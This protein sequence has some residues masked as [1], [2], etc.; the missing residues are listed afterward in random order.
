[1]ARQQPVPLTPLADAIRQLLPALLPVTDSETIAPLAAVGRILSNDFKAPLSVPPWDNSAMDGYAVRTADLE[2]MPQQLRLTQR[3]VAGSR[4]QPLRPGE[5]ARIFTGAPL[6]VG[7]DAVVMQ[8]NARTVAGEVLI[9]QRVAA[10]ENVRRA[11]GDMQAGRILFQAGHRLRPQDLGVLGAVGCTALQVRRKPRVALFSTG[12]ELVPPGSALAEGP[13]G[14]QPAPTAAIYNAN[15]YSLTALLA[16][17]PAEVIDFG[18]VADQVDASLRV[19]RQAAASADCIIST[20]GVSVGEED[21]VRAA[22]TAGGSLELWQLAIKPGKP[23]A[24]G[25]VDGTRFFGLPGNPVSAFVTFVLLVRPLLLSMLG[26]QRAF[27]RPMPLPAGFDTLR[28]GPRQEYL[29]VRLHRDHRSG[30]T[31]RPLPDQGSG[32][33]SSLSLA[34]GLAIIPPDSRIRAGELLDYLPFSELV[35]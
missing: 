35:F 7:A 9:R 10:G 4:G 17:L 18:I 2:R 15:T 32:V 22:V 29:R 23:F 20:G 25:T 1:M 26:C 27:P 3:I 30:L 28:S 34:D 5:A 11:G 16:T 14:R 8:E 13:A 6:P 33:G 19:L 12:D 24:S 21:H 31:L